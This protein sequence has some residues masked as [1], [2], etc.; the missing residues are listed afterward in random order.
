MQLTYMCVHIRMRSTYTQMK[1]EITLGEKNKL[2]QLNILNAVNINVCAH[3]YA[4]HI[5]TNG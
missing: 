3:S 2:S 1:R 5:H 4:Q